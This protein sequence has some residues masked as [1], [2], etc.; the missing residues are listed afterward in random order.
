LADNE[1]FEFRQ[2]LEREQAALTPAATRRTP[3]Q[4]MSWEQYKQA[5]ER[6]PYESAARVTDIAA[7]FLPPGG[8]AAV[9]TAARVLPEAAQMMTGANIGKA[10]VPLFEAGARNVMQRAIKPTWDQ[11]KSGDAAVAIDTLLEKGLNP[12]QGGV[13]ALKEMI[14]VLDKEVSGRVDFAKTY[15]GAKVKLSDIAKDMRSTFREFANQVD[16]GAD[17][18]TLRETW[19]RFKND[20]FPGGRSEMDVTKAHELKRGTYKR[21]GEKPY[22]KVTNPAG[23]SA[24]MSLASALR[25]GVGRAVPEAMPALEEEAKLMKTLGVTERRALMELNKNLG[26]LALL[27]H[28]PEGF[29]AFMADKSAAF[30]SIVARML[31]NMPRYDALTAAGVAIPGSMSLQDLS[32]R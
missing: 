13:Q 27:T 2:R 29:A 18:K 12:T 21:L 26:G 30:K 19:T 17:L 9:G 1:E 22:D 31:Y 25:S 28:S 15:F 10:T 16:R 24:Q 20:Y 11:L 6:A 4:M 7:K 23:T 5:S 3:R 8:A 14:S 32:Q